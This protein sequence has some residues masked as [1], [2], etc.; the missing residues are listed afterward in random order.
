M[1]HAIAAAIINALTESDTPAVRDA[2]EAV[3]STLIR[4]DMLVKCVGYSEDMVRASENWR[5]ERPRYEWA[6]TE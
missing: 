6:A 3:I 5:G 2:G 4:E 1:D